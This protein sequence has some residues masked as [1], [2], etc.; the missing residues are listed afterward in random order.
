MLQNFG[1]SGF[2]FA[3]IAFDVATVVTSQLP[4]FSWFGIP[5][6]CNSLLST[7]AGR[8]IVM[9]QDFNDLELQE[10]ASPHSK[11]VLLWLLSFQNT[12]FFSV[13]GELRSLRRIGLAFWR[14]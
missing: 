9:S 8:E 1:G 3:V 13:L 14:L 6:G 11:V 4:P 2:N 7:A 5:Y 10:V 12:C